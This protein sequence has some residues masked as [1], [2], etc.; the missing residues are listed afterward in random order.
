VAFAGVQKD[1]NWHK[2]GKALILTDGVI[3]YL[4]DG[5]EPVRLFQ[6]EAEV[7]EI[8]RK[9]LEKLSPAERTLLGLGD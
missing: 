1:A 2:T 4:I 6:D 8:K 3:G 7:L 9:V 5:E